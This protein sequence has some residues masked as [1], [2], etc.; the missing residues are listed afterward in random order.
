VPGGLASAN[1]WKRLGVLV[2]G[3]LMNLL[4]AVIVMF[5]IIA[6][7]G[8]AV[9]G[10]VLIENVS[11]NSPA[12]AAGLQPKDEFVSV[13]GKAVST[14]DEARALIRASLDHPLEIV[15]L[16]GDE[17]VK[18]TAT[19]LSSR[20]AEQ[21]ALGIGLTYP[22]RAATI[23]EVVGGGFLYTGVQALSILYI[24][25]GLIQGAIAPD[26]A[27]LVGLKGI[28]DFFGQA[29]TRDT[30]SRQ[31][32]EA[33]ASSG[34]AAPAQQPTNYVLSV[35]AMLSISLGVFNLLPIPALDGG[36]IL[37][38]LPEILFRRRIPPKLENVING[39]AML[40]LIALMLVI[41]VMDFV[42]PANIKLP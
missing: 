36:R 32:V 24:P 17:K 26:E 4:T 13:N 8:V 38:T 12:Q 1:P 16:R 15:V 37:F 29:V 21:G 3:P 23:G 40:M 34:S 25:I 19:P 33:A 10:K 42:N 30:E 31:A 5:I 14:L 27:R 18:L 22:R 9:P 11:E 28:Y 6:Q 39:V 2:A 20:T 41:N 7:T 35:I